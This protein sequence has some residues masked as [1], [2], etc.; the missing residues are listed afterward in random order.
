MVSVFDER[1]NKFKIL[2]NI[3][4]DNIDSRG[5]RVSDTA[6]IGQSPNNPEMTV[7]QADDPLI[8]TIN[9]RGNI[10]LELTKVQFFDIRN[11]LQS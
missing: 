8:P 1:D 11:R 3:K 5:I 4:D 7:T 6:F 2:T 10:I 9:A